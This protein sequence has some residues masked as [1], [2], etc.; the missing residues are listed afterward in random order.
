MFEL[1]DGC[2]VYGECVVLLFV[3]VGYVLVGS[4]V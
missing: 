3:V 2:V 1:G 4:V